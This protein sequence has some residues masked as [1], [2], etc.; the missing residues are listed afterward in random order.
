[1]LENWCGRR[2]LLKPNT[3]R[4]LP[5]SDATVYKLCDRQIPEA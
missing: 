3:G 2:P 5:K 1:M 4:M